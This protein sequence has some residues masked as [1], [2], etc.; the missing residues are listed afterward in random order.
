VQSQSQLNAGALLQRFHDRPEQA[1]LEKL[2]G[3]PIPALQN[4]SQE[5]NDTLERIMHSV[6]AQRLRLLT[7]KAEAGLDADEMAELRELHRW[8]AEAGRV[9]AQE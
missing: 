2:Q 1:A 6:N 5:L 7:E 4:P 8:K 3:L 9:S